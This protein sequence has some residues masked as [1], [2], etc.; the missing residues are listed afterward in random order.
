M[1]TTICKCMSIWRSS[2][3]YL[4]L[5]QKWLYGYIAE[6][7]RNSL[8]NCLHQMGDPWNS[9]KTS[10]YTRRMFRFH[11]SCQS[12]GQIDVK[13]HEM[14]FFPFIQFHSVRLIIFL[15]P[16]QKDPCSFFSVTSEKKI[17]YRNQYLHFMYNNVYT[18][19]VNLYHIYRIKGIQQQQQS[20]YH[21]FVML[22]N[23]WVQSMHQQLQNLEK[24]KWIS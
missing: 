15:L 2:L 21:V 4:V 16:G 3:V 17:E 10:R 1:G 8:I 5:F 9:Q 24:Q 22:S 14:D 20:I 18:Q 13:Y 6:V 19:Y 11:L 12:P 23:P 7:K